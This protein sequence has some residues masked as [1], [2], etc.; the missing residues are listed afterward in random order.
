MTSDCKQ[1]EEAKDLFEMVDGDFGDDPADNGVNSLSLST[2][3]F[4]ITSSTTHLDVLASLPM[5][6]VADRLASRFFNTYTPSR[7]KYEDIVS[8]SDL[9]C[10]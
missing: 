7:C 2:L 10:T 4:E 1:I 6:S 3:A 9:I 5:Q 8:V